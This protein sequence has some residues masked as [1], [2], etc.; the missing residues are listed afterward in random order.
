MMSESSP[1]GSFIFFQRFI[2]VMVSLCIQSS[3]MCP[4]VLLLQYGFIREGSFIMFAE[5]IDKIDGF[6]WG[7]P[8]IIL[9]FGT[10]IFMT[11]RTGFIQ[12]DIFRED[13]NC[14][15]R[16]RQRDNERV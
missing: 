8:L 12:K 7:W 4:S 16:Y 2:E 3:L 6:V 5:I 10:H 15:R 1:E 13:G 9:L 11:V 14:R